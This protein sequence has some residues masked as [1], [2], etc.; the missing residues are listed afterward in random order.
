MRKPWVFF[1]SLFALGSSV[2][3]SGSPLTASP[4]IRPAASTS[5]TVL[6]ALADPSEAP[7]FCSVDG[8]QMGIISDIAALL[9]K[10]SQQTIEML[11]VTT[12]DEYEAHLKAKDY[13]LLL[14]ASDSFSPSLLSGYDLTN[15]I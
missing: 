11:P 5:T 1:L 9:G 4:A 2:F 12:Y 10:E 8:E 15:S 3:V 13:D 6:K 7:Y 14:G